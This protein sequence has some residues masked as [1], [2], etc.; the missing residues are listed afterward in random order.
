LRSINILQLYL[1][2]SYF[3]LY[4]LMKSISVV[5]TIIC[6]YSLKNIC[7]CLYIFFFY[8][9]IYIYTAYCTSSWEIQPY[10]NVVSKITILKNGF[11]ATIKSD[12]HHSDTRHNKF[13]D[14]EVY[15]CP[16]HGKIWI[17]IFQTS[18]WIIPTKP[19]L[20]CP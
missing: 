10:K 9:Y 3:L 15:H 8:L 11:R 13:S 14:I 4:S 12:F 19:C 20:K 18:T 16:Y 2:P 1:V 6:S 5:K 7:W 17:L